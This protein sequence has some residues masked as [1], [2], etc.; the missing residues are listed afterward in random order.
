MMVMM[1]M[2]MVMMMV[3][4]MTVMLIMMMMVVVMTCLWTLK[5]LRQQPARQTFRCPPRRQHPAKL[6]A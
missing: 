6:P 4:M 3:M 2:M 5:H 1:M